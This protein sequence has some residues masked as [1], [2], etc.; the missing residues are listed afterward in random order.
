MTWT[1]VTG[2]TG[3]IGVELV[4]ALLV[5]GESVRVFSRDQTRQQEVRERLEGDKFPAERYRFFVGDVRDRD[6]LMRAFQGV[7]TVYHLA[8]LK[9]VDSCEYNPD[10]TI[11]TNVQGALNVIDAAIACGVERVIYSSSD[12]AAEPNS[13][14]GASKLIAEKL[15]VNANWHAR[16]RFTT[17][18]FGNVMGSRGSVIPNWERQLRDVGRIKVTDPDM[19]RYVMSTSQAV[20]L[21]L[22]AGTLVGGEVV[23]RRMPAVR[24]LDL[25]HV[26]VERYERLHHV[27]KGSTKW[28]IVGARPGETISEMVLTA[29]E[30]SRSVTDGQCY[31]LMPSMQFG[32]RDY[33]R[34]QSMAKLPAKAIDS[35]DDAPVS[36]EA[37]RDL[38][39]I[40]GV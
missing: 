15:I 3:D 40:W 36:R 14:M 30:A 28:D 10:E 18:R 16:C 4:K 37:L 31:Y 32:A 21:L 25:V 29:E 8:A 39:G 27:E 9:H 2:G 26:F 5:R 38:M 20:D 23:I 12:K 1:L 24:L 7:G 34:Y 33:S 35:H 11:K 22:H 17:A 13:M 19:T 6:R